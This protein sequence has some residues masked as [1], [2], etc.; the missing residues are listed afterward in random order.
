[1]ATQRENETDHPLGN[2]CGAT[3][4]DTGFLD[5][6][7]DRL[8][9]DDW[10]KLNEAEQNNTT[11]GHNIIQPKIRILQNK[12]IPIKHHF[13]GKDKKLGWPIQLPRG[14]GT[15]DNEEKGILNGAINVTA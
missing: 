7:K 2:Q 15:N 10:L 9:E 13:D 6:V 3:F 5:F 1:M 14:I 12:F 4:V 11:G 8:G